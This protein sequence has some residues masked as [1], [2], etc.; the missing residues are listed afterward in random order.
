MFVPAEAAAG[1]VFIGVACG[2]HMYLSGKIAGN[3][4]ALKAVLLLRDSDWREAFF[5]GGLLGGGSLVGFVMPGR[6]EAVPLDG[7]ASLLWR[8]LCGMAVGVGTTLG[9]GCTSGHGMLIASQT[10]LCHQ[11]L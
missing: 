2:L 5:L 7:C 9:N 11:C 4:G 10:T 6:F 8:V 3:S 1:G